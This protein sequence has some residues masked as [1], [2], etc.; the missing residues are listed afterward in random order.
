MP[1][2]IRRGG[3]FL[4]LVLVALGAEFALPIIIPDTAWRVLV[5][6][7]LV[8][9]VIALSLNVINGM[10]GQFS[11]GHAGFV[12]IGAYTGAVVS[13][14]IHRALGSPD[15]DFATSFM[16]MPPAIIAAGL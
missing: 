4:A 3:L 12:G 8:S 11:I 9:V 13:S 16:I 7:A 14:Q 5:Q 6:Q 1:A 10:A 15:Y 2:W